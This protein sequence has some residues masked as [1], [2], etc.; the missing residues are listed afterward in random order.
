MT[1]ETDLV[2]V[3][4]GIAG[5][6]AG[7]FAARLGLRVTMFAPEGAIGALTTI[8][9]VEDFPGFPGGIS[10]YELSPLLQQQSIDAGV[11]LQMAAVTHLAADGR[12]WHLATTDADIGAAAVIVATGSRALPLAVPGESELTGRG[13]SHCASCDGPLFRNKMVVVAGG[14]DSALQESLT[15]AGLG[16]H[17][18]IVE[19]APTLSAQQV[20][21]ERL[22]RNRNIEVQLG[23]RIERIA[24]E[25]N[26]TGV[27]LRDEKSGDLNEESVDGVFVYVGREAETTLLEGSEV[28]DGRGRLVTDAEMRSSRPGLFAA[29]D[30][31]AASSGQ[32]AAA[33]GDGAAAARAVGDYLG[34]LR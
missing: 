33:A 9:L 6:T 27:V 22:Q 14:G 24:G 2:I 32:A 7:L 34:V 10:G 1:N 25:T 13:V 18:K 31:R 26:V 5:S 16:V 21:R 11:E 12:R 28:L 15:L 29:G 4:G 8:D 17:V 3:G 19:A 23:A 20:F 30:V